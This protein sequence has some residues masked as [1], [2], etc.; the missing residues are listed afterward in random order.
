MSVHDGDSVTRIKVEDAAKLLGLSENA[1][2][3]RI[4]RGSIKSEKVG[5]T[6]YVILSDTDMPRRDTDMSLES[7]ALI[8]EMRS[9]IEF[10]ED[11]LRRKDTILMSLVQ[12]VP[13]LE[14]VPESRE[15]LVTAAGG[16]EGGE[17]PPDGEKR[18]WW[19]KFFDL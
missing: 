5:D 3:K 10:L 18:S 8:S 19:R 13:E 6:R 16:P 17:V 14:P 1:I 7:S 12:R 4:E 11:E 2:R 9:R 15:S